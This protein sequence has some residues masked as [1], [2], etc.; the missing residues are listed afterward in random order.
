MLVQMNS[1]S[2]EIK[3]KQKQTNLNKVYEDWVSK[4]NCKIEFLVLYNRHQN[5]M[6]M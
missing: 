6:Q 5:S 2:L 4:L 1:N 3:Q